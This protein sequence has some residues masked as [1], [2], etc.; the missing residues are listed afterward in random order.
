MPTDDY[1]WL[2]KQ[3]A[4]I[5]NEADIFQEELSKKVD[6]ILSELGMAVHQGKQLSQRLS[7]ESDRY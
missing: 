1:T 5:R 2:S 3:L 7:G 6:S 4:Y